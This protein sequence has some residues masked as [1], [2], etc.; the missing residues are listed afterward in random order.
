MQVKYLSIFFLLIFIISFDFAQTKEEAVKT[1]SLEKGSWS[2]QFQISEN[3]TLQ[4]FQ[5][6]MISTKYHF[7][8]KSAL[9]TGLSISGRSSDIEDNIEQDSDTVTTYINTDNNNYNYAVKI[10]T[11]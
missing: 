7:T 1:N 5:G 3:F 8:E 6:S 4:S 11:S 10:N 2:L 9:R